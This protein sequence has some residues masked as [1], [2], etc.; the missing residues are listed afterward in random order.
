MTLDPTYPTVAPP[1]QPKIHRRRLL[2]ALFGVTGVFLLCGG[3]KSAAAEQLTPS[4]T[5][6]PDAPADVSPTRATPANSKSPLPA[7]ANKSG[8]SADGAHYPSFAIGSDGVI[9]RTLAPS[10]VLPSFQTILKAP[11]LSQFD[12][13][14]YAQTNCGP[15]SL[16][17]ALGALGV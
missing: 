1:N 11:Y 4:T 3:T 6:A 16:A 5:T 10:P 2:P 12:G 15:T 13:S 17:M 14:A 8:K 9:R 7:P